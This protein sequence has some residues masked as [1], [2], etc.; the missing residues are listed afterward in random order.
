MGG[1]MQSTWREWAVRPHAVIGLWLA[2]CLVR[3]ALLPLTGTDPVGPDD[4]MRLFEV[5]D[6]LAGQSWWDVTQYRVDPPDGAS[7]HWSRLVDLPLAA[8]AFAFGETAA[9]VVVPLLYLLVALF[10]LR[11]IMQR[12]GFGAGALLCGL[13]IMPFFPLLPGNFAPMRIDHHAPQAV[14]G[15]ACAALLLGRGRISAI[16]AGLLSAAWVVVSLEGLPLVAVLAGLFG[17]QYWLERETRLAW[18]L[19]ALALVA[20]ALSLA[21]RPVAEC[22]LPF[23][24]IL[25]PG[26]MAAFAA[27]AVIA[28]MLPILPG[29]GQV[30]G[31]FIALCL[32]PVICAPMAWVTLGNCAADPFSRL[33]PLLQQYWH[34]M[35]TEGLPL[36]RQPLSVAMTL[37][38]GVVLVCAGWRVARRSGANAGEASAAWNLFALMALAAACYSFLLMRAGV[39]AQ[40][41]AIPFAAFLLAHYLPQARAI[42]SA[43]P[44]I[45]ATLACFLLATPMLASAGF[46][47]LDPL[48]ARDTMREDAIAMIEGAR[49]DYARLDALAPGLVLAPLDNGPEILGKS[50][51]AIVMASYHRNQQGMRDV[52]SA[53]VGSPEQARAVALAHDADYV[54][55]CSSEA[56]LAL[57]RTADPANFANAVV[58]DVPPDWLEPVPGF[59]EGSL[60]AYRIRQD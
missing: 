31:R 9:L 42:P 26:H 50:E 40:L 6:L 58:G 53:F 13:A 3:L 39:V 48:L 57:Y 52:L 5:R 1:K 54:V 18:F 29:Q 11:A 56:D 19:G 46:K 24:D 14:L 35:I 27:A 34:G 55:A 7:M 41:L 44:R 47:P 59:A 12:L 15:L 33:D 8:F 30:R 28:A 38:W 16:A 60:R 20:P 10:A 21:T 17:L 37:V 49:C 36:W 25:M 4:Y 2:Y 32:I 51:H 43:L 45:I 22:A 23:C